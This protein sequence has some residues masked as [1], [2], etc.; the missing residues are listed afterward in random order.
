VDSADLNKDEFIAS[1]IDV[2]LFCVED[3]VILK[4][5]LEGKSW[6]KA[7]GGETGAMH[8]WGGWKA[9]AAGIKITDET[10]NLIRLVK[11]AEIVARAKLI[12]KPATP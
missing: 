9:S 6:A 7:L 5:V 12:T 4:R 11:P 2:V 10:G 8:P 1:V 3:Q